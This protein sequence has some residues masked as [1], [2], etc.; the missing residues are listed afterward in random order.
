MYFCSRVL[1]FIIIVLYGTNVNADDDVTRCT[2]ENCSHLLRCGHIRRTWQQREQ[3]W[4]ASASASNASVE[5]YI[6]PPRFDSLTQIEQECFTH[7]GAIPVDTKMHVDD[8]GPNNEG[9]FYR[10]TSRQIEEMLKIG[11]NLKRQIRNQ[12]VTPRSALVRH[13]RQYRM[14]APRETDVWILEALGSDRVRQALRKGEGRV[15]LFGSASPFY[16]SLIL[17]Y[18]EDAK[19]ITTVEYNRLEYEHESMRT[20]TAEAFWKERTGRISSSLE[21]TDDFD[22]AVSFSSF[23][24]DGLGRYG[25][26][27]AP[28]GDLTTMRHIL[29]HVLSPNHGVLLLTIPIGPDLLAWNLMRVYGSVRLP[30]LLRGWDVLE[31]V[32]YDE[33]RA[34]DTKRDFRRTYEPVFVLAPASDRE[35]NAKASRRSRVVDEAEL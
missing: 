10:Y 25:D 32:G 33:A 26:P 29:Q 1:H 15:V 12:G 22:L 16:E 2:K 35:E 9:T 18:C 19:E 17:E 11:R 13:A 14:R 23:D 21:A 28:D 34:F 31:R 27:I 20:V 6:P 8:S 3:P 30:L 5:T 4:N 7:H 24:H